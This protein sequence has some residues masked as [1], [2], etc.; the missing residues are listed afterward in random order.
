LGKKIKE[1]LPEKKCQVIM[2]QKVN[3]ILYRLAILKNEWKYKFASKNSEELS[4]YTFQNIEI[5]RYLKQ[6][7]S[8][9][10]MYLHDYKIFHTMKCLYLYVSYFPSSKIIKNLQKIR[11][12][13]AFIGLNTKRTQISVFLNDKM[14]IYKKYRKFFEI[15]KFIYRTILTKNSFLQQI[16]ESLT[17][18]LSKKVN[19]IIIFQQVRKGLSLNLNE[20][21]NSHKKI[22]KNR[23]LALRKHSKEP[24]F[25]DMLNI[26]VLC[27]N[28]KNSGAILAEFIS[29]KLQETK[30]HGQFFYLLKST[31]ISLQKT[32]I[33]KINGIKIKIKGRL[34]G[35][36]R[37][38]SKLITVG[39]IPTQTLSHY[40]DFA[41][42]TSYTNNGTFGIKIWST[43][44]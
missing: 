19:I 9:L 42:A 1:N 10:G 13:R 37:S 28:L 34:N 31:L 6:F 11:R 18:F 17:L 16:L 29:K 14:P 23:F 35:R 32:K 33:S 4:L 15:K 8:E 26:I 2:G 41:E 38:T 43:L 24:S 36:A 5:K 39:Q 7:L 25:I 44:K 3:P 22:I 40:V 12:K 21:T 30:R 27:L 20:M